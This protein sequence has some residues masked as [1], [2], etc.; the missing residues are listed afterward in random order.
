[1]RIPGLDKSAFLGKGVEHPPDFGLTLRRSQLDEECLALGD[2]YRIEFVQ[3]LHLSSTERR[4]VDNFRRLAVAQFNQG[5][6]ILVQ[7]GTLVE[8]IYYL[9]HT[10]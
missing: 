2:E 9:L 1:M 7:P 4:Q 10:F 5:M 8:G 3:R 6:E